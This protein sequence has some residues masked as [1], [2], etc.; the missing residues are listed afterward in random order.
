MRIVI[1]VLIGCL[2]A[3]A[4][5]VKTSH[6][7][8]SSE[9]DYQ[10]GT[11]N[12]VVAT[13]LGDLKLSRQVKTLVEQDARFSAVFAMAQSP[14]GT[15]YAGTGPD[16][17]L[18]AIRDDK[19]STA[20]EL[21][22]HV[23]LFSL[24]V[25]SRGRL[26][27]GT[28]GEKG[29]ILRIDKPG[30]K[31]HSIF[32]SDEV[33]YIWAMAQ[34]PDGNVYAAT[35]PNGQLFQINPDGSH[36]VLFDCNENNLLCLLSDGGDLLYIGTDPNGLIYRVN[37]KTG[38][39]FV[40]YDSQQDEISALARDS[41]GNL[42]AGSSNSGQPS[43]NS[44]EP[45]HEG[46]PEGDSH[47]SAIPSLPRRMPKPADSPTTMPG[48]V[49]GIPKE[50]HPLSMMI[51]QAADEPAA[52]PTS[53][54]A[55]PG[56]SLRR[57]S[58]SGSPPPSSS[59]NNNVIYRIDPEGFVTEVF[60]SND[61]ILA[62]TENDGAILAA[63]GEEGNIYQINPQA[64]ETT[65]LAKLDP[66]QVLCLL[67]VKDGRVFLGTANAGQIGVLGAGFASEGTFVS[68]VLDAEQISRF[69]K[70]ELR[71][72]LPS[73]TGLK[74]STRSGNVSE[75]DDAGWSKWSDD[76][77]ASEFVQNPS[78][79]ARYLQYRLTFSSSDGKSTPTVDEIDVAYQ[80]PN[81]A[82]V[83]KS[84][85]V[86]SDRSDEDAPA[87]TKMTIKWDAT[88]A[89]E[90]DLEY[91]L[92]FRMGTAGPWILL[93]EKV[94]DPTYDWETRN[95]A[96]GRYQIK[97][98]ASDAAANPTGQGKT[99]SRVS[100]PVVVDNTVPVIG[101]VKIAISGGKV[102]ISTHV[103]DRTSTVALLQYSIDSAEHWQTVLP[104]DNIADS[105]EEAYSFD[106]PG[107]SGG[108]HQITFRATD[109]H[110]NRAF[111]SVNVTVEK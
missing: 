40:V 102:N 44:A 2:T 43:E 97:V 104:S 88:D 95:V 13:N 14:D 57:K 31:P 28:G 23:N 54:P 24:L 68:Q 69:G 98:D 67:P 103:T 108:T 32:S 93:K 33:K 41:H 78:P 34:T 110:G 49:P 61:T 64:D 25:D 105:P 17:I 75:E 91:N 100:D 45:D 84:I 85:K 89:N 20:A 66:K 37:R 5:A 46:R 52:S 22:E 74:I 111:E 86:T 79:A 18:L 42:Y 83:V 72:T 71:G 55:S 80:S 27:I 10:R 94:K 65:L 109:S 4:W 77:P 16:G 50:S 56:K 12:H 63:T 11:F 29:E 76:L 92:Y 36:K 47:D 99:A 51:L 48:E 8:H 87:K 35:G 38:D 19:I 3:P 9:S 1:C 21:G 39:A 106:V 90:D 60:H 30:D 96:D 70:I 6:W 59:G 107:L 82:P 62:M 26:L 53:A 7:V 15:I 101:D 58:A 81:L 73:G